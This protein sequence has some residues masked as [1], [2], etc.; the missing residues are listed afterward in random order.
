MKKNGTG[1]IS[2]TATT[3]KKHLDWFKGLEAIQKIRLSNLEQHLNWNQCTKQWH[4]NKYHQPNYT[5]FPYNKHQH[6]F[7]HPMILSS[8]ILL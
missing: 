1:I 4:E 2:S 5:A 7:N 6:C 8:T 3:T